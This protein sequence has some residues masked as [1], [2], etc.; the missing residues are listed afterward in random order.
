MTFAIGVPISCRCLG[1]CLASRDLLRD[2]VNFADGSFEALVVTIVRA[3]S[4]PHHDRVKHP[5]V[6]DGVHGDRHAVPAQD[7]LG[8]HVEADR[9][10][11]HL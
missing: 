2:C 9:A 6:D 10:Q 3:L 11:V 4:P 7:L 1:A 5:V 8:R